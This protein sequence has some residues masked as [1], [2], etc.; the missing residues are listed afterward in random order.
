MSIEVAK[1]EGSGCG[2]KKRRDVGFESRRAR[3]YGWDI[4]VVEFPFPP[5]SE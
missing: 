5:G 2:K 3:G 1:D 4:D